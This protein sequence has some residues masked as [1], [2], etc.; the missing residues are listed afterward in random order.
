M[1]DR[2]ILREFERL[3]RMA[4][5]RVRHTNDPVSGLCVVKGERVIFIGNAQ[6]ER[7]R[8]EIFAASF[9]NVDL[10]GYFVVPVLRRIIYGDEHEDW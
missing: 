6:D 8:I 10:D 3:A 2:I 7:Q 9:R 5:I 1:D 4:G